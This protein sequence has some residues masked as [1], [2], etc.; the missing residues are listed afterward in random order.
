MSSYIKILGVYVLVLLCIGCGKPIE[1]GNKKVKIRYLTY[2]VMPEQ[3]KYLK[4]IEQKFEQAYPNIDL[5]IETSTSG[6]QKL[7]IMLAGGDAPDVFL[8][9]DE[10]M[11]PLVE[12]DVIADLTPLINADN[13]DLNA[14]FPEVTNAFTFES[15]IYG[16]PVQFDTDALYYNKNLFD[17]A[18]L[19]YP[20]ENWT[21][22]DFLAAAK[23]LTKDTNHDGKPDQF[24]C[25]RPDYLLVARSNG[26]R[27]FSPDLKKCILNT[28]EAVAS[29]KFVA[30]IETK[31]K[32]CPTQEQ[33][34]DRAGIQGE[35]LFA[36]GKI[37]MFVGRTYQVVELT[38]VK[39]FDW[40]ICPFPKGKQ[41]RAS[42]LQAEAN[43][44]WVGT[45]H[46]NETWEFMKFYSSEKVLSIT[47]AKKNSV[48][49]LK[50]VALSTVYCSPPPEHIKL[51]IDAL[52]YAEPAPRMTNYN[53][54]L[55]TIFRPELD[56]VFLNQKKP[57]QAINDIVSKAD[58]FLQGK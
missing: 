10:N 4:Q 9:N 32:V 45:K 53:E 13:L 22:D 31:Y 47:G 40:D 18:N 23:K 15:G 43:C 16:L 28:P 6:L 29:L 34:R 41:G 33:M 51:F 2:E 54:F 7:L 49:A 52:A 48:P 44:M 57:E 30:D 25:L 39:E 5:K 36:T 58:K 35:N 26:V 19:P 37:A 27:L 8:W 14:Y 3:Q 24:G 56:L 1:Q 55:E 50:S 11:T 46:P 38:K 42:R 17:A 21:W 12:K 20:N